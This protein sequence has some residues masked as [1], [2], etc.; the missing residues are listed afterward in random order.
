MSNHS[1]YGVFGST[2]TSVE[3]VNSKAYSYFVDRIHRI[4]NYDHNH[5]TLDRGHT[6][7]RLSAGFYK[8]Q[9]DTFG[10]GMQ[11]LDDYRKI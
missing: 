1:K 8:K 9:P 6:L 11:G 7:G 5:F 10:S 3:G 4:R 2:S